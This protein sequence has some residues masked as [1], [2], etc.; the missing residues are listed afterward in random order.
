MNPIQAL[1]QTELYPD[2]HRVLRIF[3][4]RNSQPCICYHTHLSLSTLFLSFSNFFVLFQAKCIQKPTC[5]QV[6]YEL[7]IKD[8]N[9][10][11]LESESSALPLGECPIFCLLVQR[12]ELL[13][14]TSFYLSTPF[15]IF[16]HF[17]IFSISKQQKMPPKYISV[18]SCI[19]YSP[20]LFPFFFLIMDQLDFNGI[21]QCI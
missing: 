12:Q 17:F 1:Y 20:W 13:Y 5:Y 9:L 18:T 19:L 16:F 15:F 2:F 6:G 3:Q 4:S 10:G 8:S 21:Y 14:I 7:G 11:M